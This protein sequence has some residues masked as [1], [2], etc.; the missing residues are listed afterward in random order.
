MKT[1]GIEILSNYYQFKEYVAIGITITIILLYLLYYIRKCIL[2]FRRAARAL[3]GIPSA[4]GSDHFIFGHV[5]T[6]LS[7][8]TPWGKQKE[9]LLDSDQKH[10]KFR[11]IDKSIFF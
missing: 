11:I 9:L 2:E 10:L 3:K 6:M 5:F 7:G 1:L 4:P 8:R